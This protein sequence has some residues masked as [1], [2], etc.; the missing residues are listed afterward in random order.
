MR[1]VIFDLWDTLVEW[2]AAEAAELRERIATLVGVTEDEFGRRWAESYR[3]SQ[4]GPLA[5]AYA[6]LGVPDE[7]VD[8]EVAA[9]HAFARRALHPRAGAAAV[10]AELRRR[11]IRLGLISVC[12]EEV[13]AA[14]SATELAG[15]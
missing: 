15:L 6:T 2:P 7:H 11:G 12:S 13:P 5:T 1:A 14:W 9:R 4:T 8:A 10:L 3:P